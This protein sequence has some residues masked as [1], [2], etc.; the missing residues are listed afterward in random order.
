MLWDCVAIVLISI[1]SS[2]LA[3]GMSWILIYRHDSYKK[4]KAQ[5][6]DLNKKLDKK[7]DAI[8]DITKQRSKEKRVKDLEEQLKTKSKDMAMV[9]FQSTFFVMITLIAIFGMLNN[10]YDGLVVGKL[11]FMPIPLIRGMT[12]RGLPGSDYTDCSM[13][14]LYVLCSLCIRPNVQKYLGFAPPK[15][16]D[17][18]SL[19]GAPA[20]A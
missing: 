17:S 6:D 15:T 12:H 2:F 18:A 7:K 11:P 1:A 14:F 16:A 13:V 9:K 3:E 5:I 19:F 8:A 10:V 4:L 20:P